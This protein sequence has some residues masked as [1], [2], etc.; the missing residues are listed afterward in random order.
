MFKPKQLAEFNQTMLQGGAPDEINFVGY[1]KPDFSVCMGYLDVLT[2]SQLAD[3]SSRLV[4][5]CKTQLKISQEEM[6]ETVNYYNSLVG[7]TQLSQAISIKIRDQF[8]E[9]AFDYNWQYVDII[10]KAHNRKY[11]ANSKTWYIHNSEVLTVLEK[12]QE[13]GADCQNAIKY[14]AEHI[15]I[16]EQQPKQ[17]PSAI[18]I[19]AERKHDKL[20]ISFPYN[21]EIIFCVKSL[22][23]RKYN[24]ESKNWTI[25][26]TE[27]NSLIS[28][29]SKLANIDYSTLTQFIQIEKPE[30]KI[31]ITIPEGLTKKPFDHQVQAAEFLLNKKKAI[32]AD[33]MGGGKTFSSILASYN[34]QGKKLV[35]CPA[36]LKLNWKKEIDFIPNQKTEVI[37]GK[38]WINCNDWTIVNYDI[39]SKHIDQILAE[40]FQV[41]IFDEAHYCK[42][43]NN[44]GKPGSQRANFFLQIAE[45]I[46]NVYLLTGTPITNH[47]KDIFNLLKAINHPLAKKFFSFGQYYCGGQH[48]G[49]GWDFNGSSNSEE[50][51]EKIKPFML[52]RLKTEML[53]LPEKIRSFIPVSINLKEYDKKV[54]EYMD[55]RESLTDQGEHLVYLNAMRHILAKEKVSHTIE[56]TKNLLE[57]DQQVVIMTNYN[58]VVEQ[59]LKEFGDI[60][61]KLTGDCSQE[62]RQ[63]AVDQFQ[64]GNKKVFVG[65][66]IAAGVGITLTASHTMLINDYDWVPANHAQG[67]DR[68]HRIGQDEKVNIQ[69]VY[70][71]KTFDE[72]IT[73][74]L[75]KKLVN[76]SQ[77]VDGREE[78]F[79]T[80][81]INNF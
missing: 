20:T 35:V 45:K 25:D 16:T 4:K 49:Y 17:E 39:L 57:Q 7:N 50:L 10:K 44:S 74:I 80:E 14:F 53:D 43:I 38:G 81:I 15:K 2:D 69:Y 42:S 61:V 59:I 19:K 78:N 41:V 46:E 11:I 8:T 55:N 52:R 36:S 48:N 23:N 68:I 26:I 56:L 72:N 70:A 66:L 5:Y 3:L 47:T 31:S 77:I 73:K 1:N 12:L 9:L 6:I 37:N 64:T 51:H 54:K 33:E 22:M 18:Q 29:L 58:F 65:N 62:Q 67:E 71:D 24:P 60:A 34:V 28:K 63:K 13:I 79:I 75:E 21:A 27:V 40:N 30:Q 32:L 76:I